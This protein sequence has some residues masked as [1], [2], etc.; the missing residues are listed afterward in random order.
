MLRKT[1]IGLICAASLVSANALAM[2]HE[3]KAGLSVEYEFMPHMPEIL[4]NFTIFTLTA[5]C[6]I[7]IAEPTPAPD[8]DS[9]PDSNPNVGNYIL[10][11]KALYSSGKI[12]GQDFSKGDE[13][14][15]PVK[16][17]DV[18][19]LTAYPAARVEFTNIGE[20]TIKALCKMI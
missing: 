13:M 20:T 5:A 3:L 9:S 16:N 6:T 10:H 4:M 7:Q 18:I 19:T 1:A 15:Y 8:S 11:V 17:G 14:D 2:S 12:N